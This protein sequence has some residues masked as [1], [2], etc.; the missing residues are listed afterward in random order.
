[1]SWEQE[2]HEEL[3]SVLDVYF[4]KGDGRRGEA[5]MLFAHAMILIGETQRRALKEPVIR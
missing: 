4:P 5:L 1:M 2:C 3:E